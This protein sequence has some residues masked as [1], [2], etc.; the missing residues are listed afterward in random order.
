MVPFE[1][2]KFLGEITTIQ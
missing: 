1:G 2:Q